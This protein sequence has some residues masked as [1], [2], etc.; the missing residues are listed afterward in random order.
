MI[1]SG[2]VNCSIID[3]NPVLVMRY[4]DP[5][6][7]NK[8]LNLVQLAAREDQK[9]ILKS[10]KPLTTELVNKPLKIPIKK[11]RSEIVL[12]ETD[13]M[14]LITAKGRSSLIH[15][16]TGDIVST[17]SQSKNLGQLQ[18][19]LAGINLTRV[20]RSN[21]VNMSQ[22]SKYQATDG[23]LF[24]NGINN[25]IQVSRRMKPMMHNLLKHL[26]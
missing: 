19:E 17:I 7:M 11:S 1:G 21:L 5:D 8:L 16:R 26:L 4:H 25:P 15:H 23:H 14:L 18:K 24:I 6:F 22:V 12:I 9:K 20:Y 3:Q 13:N 2:L 10:K